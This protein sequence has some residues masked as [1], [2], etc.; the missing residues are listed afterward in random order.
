MGA[1]RR[2][3]RKEM[4]MKAIWHAENNEKAV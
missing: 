3:M 2:K 1:A 4:P